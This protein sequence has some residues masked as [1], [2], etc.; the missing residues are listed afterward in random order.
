MN[1]EIN[2]LYVAITRAKSKLI[3][4]AEIMIQNFPPFN[5]IEVVKAPEPIRASNPYLDYMEFRNGLKE[6][7]KKRQ[8]GKEETYDVEQTGQTRKEVYGSWSPEAD[9]AL[10]RL[11]KEGVKRDE[12]CEIFGK[13]QG[14]ILSRLKK[15]GLVLKAS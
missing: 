10:K 8:T 1:E 9:D 6:K 15:L 7:G 12:L 14:V 13:S 2:L 3:I 4:P 11:F 5:C